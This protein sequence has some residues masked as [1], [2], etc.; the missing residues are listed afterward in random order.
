MGIYPRAAAATAAR[1]LTT[2]LGSWAL[3]TNQVEAAA[4]RYQGALWGDVR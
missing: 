2:S 1:M 3:V 4:D